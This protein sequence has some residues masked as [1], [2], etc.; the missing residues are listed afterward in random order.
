MEQ[1]LSRY[2]DLESQYFEKAMKRMLQNN[3]HLRRIMKNWSASDLV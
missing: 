1:E 2:V 3:T